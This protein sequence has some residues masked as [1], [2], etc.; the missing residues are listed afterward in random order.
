M[1]EL[2][3]E[4]MTKNTISVQKRSGVKEPLAVE[5]WQAQISKVCQESVND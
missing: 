1:M 3:I 2:K 5:K 4:N